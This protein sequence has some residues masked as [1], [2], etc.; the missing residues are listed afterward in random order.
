MYYRFDQST[1]VPEYDPAKGLSS[2]IFIY[3]TSRKNAEKKVADLFGDVALSF[4]DIERT[5][6]P[7]ENDDLVID[8]RM[9][10]PRR[11]IMPKG[12]YDMFIHG[13]DGFYGAHAYAK[14]ID[15]APDFY[16][17]VF[18]DYGMISPLLESD[19]DGYVREV[20]VDR[21]PSKPNVPESAPKGEEIVAYSYYSEDDYNGVEYE[22]YVIKGRDRSVMEEIFQNVE[23]HFERSKINLDNFLP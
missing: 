14:V 11:K 8:N 21:T 4:R 10:N 6:I 3:A 20:G 9:I 7:H 19:S 12:E 5:A 22:I 2:T 1:S 15:Y 18:A 17:F 16:Y 23:N 13:K